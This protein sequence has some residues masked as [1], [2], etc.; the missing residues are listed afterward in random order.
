MNLRQIFNFNKKFRKKH[1]AFSLNNSPLIQ[2]LR[3]TA[4]NIKAK[5]K[6]WI[7]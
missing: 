4:L 5:G 6:P 1:E 2:N 7:P 3:V